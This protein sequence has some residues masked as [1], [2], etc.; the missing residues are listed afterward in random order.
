[1]SPFQETWS[2]RPACR[3]DR[4]GD[5]PHHLAE[6]RRI[7]VGW[8]RSRQCKA[9]RA[10]SDPA[11]DTRPRNR[12]KRVGR[13]ERFLISTAGVALWLVLGESVFLSGGGGRNAPRVYKGR[14]GEIE[15]PDHGVLSGS[16]G[17]PGSRTL[18]SARPD[19]SHAMSI[20]AAPELT[21]LPARLLESDAFQIV[22]VDKAPCPPH[23]AT[24][25][26]AVLCGNPPSQLRR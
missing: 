22:C 2:R 10:E 15:Q 8:T 26:A 7:A 1:M 25:L 17:L 20:Y 13:A 4:L 9:Q 14:A 6:D 18:F 19:S 3:V 5:L 23:R 24:L 21:A 11:L 12:S 16:D